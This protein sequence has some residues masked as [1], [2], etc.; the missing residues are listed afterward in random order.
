MKI[1]FTSDEVREIIL[2]YT[3]AACPLGRF[4]V[5]ARYGYLP[6]V[7]V[8]YVEPEAKVEGACDAAQ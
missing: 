7:T 2:Q 6:D 3:R 4:N 8:E 1:E 5:V